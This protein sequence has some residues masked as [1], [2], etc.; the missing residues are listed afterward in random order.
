MSQ[1]TGP[2]RKRGRQRDPVAHEAVLR[3]ARELVSEVGYQKVTMEQIAERAGVARMTLYRWWSNKAAVV[4]EAVADR[5]APGPLP[6]TGS[7]RDDAVRYLGDLV[8]ALTLLGDPSVIAGALVERGEAGRADLR[9]ILTARLSPGTLLLSRGVERGELPRGLDLHTVV[10]S[11]VGF[12]LYRIVFLEQTPSP[13][14][15]TALVDLLP[16][17]GPGPGTEAGPRTSEGQG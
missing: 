7:T 11:W 6:D 5:L 17:T 1:P 4:T 10:D 16:L 13:R 14:D 15:L 12:V 8:S 3:A 9:D 2:R